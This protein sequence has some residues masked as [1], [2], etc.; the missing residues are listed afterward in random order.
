MSIPH[1]DLSRMLETSAAWFDQNAVI[2]DKEELG[3]IEDIR[4][5]F[6][7]HQALNNGAQFPYHV[8]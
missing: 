2:W 5:V 8:E 7:I 1:T 6:E 3:M 4:Q